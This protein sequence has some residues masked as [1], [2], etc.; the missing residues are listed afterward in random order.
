M[1]LPAAVGLIRVLVLE[2][3]SVRQS[4]KHPNLC[5]ITVDG[6]KADPKQP[7]QNQE[8]YWRLPNTDPRNEGK[9]LFR[10]HTLDLYFW[11]AEDAN[12][13]IGCVSKILQ[14]GQIEILDAPAIQEPQQ[15]VT[16]PVVQKLESV[17]IQDPAYQNGQTRDSRTS[18]IAETPASTASTSQGAARR[19]IHH[20]EEAGAF[21]PMAYN[22]AAPPAP[23]PI[24]HREKTPPPPDS[25]QGTGLAAAAQHDHAQAFSPMPTPLPTQSQGYTSRP[26]YGQSPLSQ[27]FS[28]PPS[29]YT[30]PQAQTAFSPPPPVS[31]RRNSS[32]SSIPQ[33]PQ[34]G[35]TMVNPY[36]ST[37]SAVSIPQSHQ[38]ATSP[39]PQQSL[40]TFGPPPIDP[41]VQPYGAEPKLKRTATAEILG[42]SYVSSEK[43]P[44]QHLQPQ[45]ADYLGSRP[46]SQQPQAQQQP[47]PPGGYANYDYS[48]Q[49]QRHHS[50]S[51]QSN[52][53]DV[54]SQVYRPTEEEAHKHRKH[55]DAG[56]GQQPGRLEQRAAKVDKGVNRLFKRVEKKLG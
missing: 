31:G 24:R 18:S 32:V 4:Y 8:Y 55:S 47:Q 10:L 30:S 27:G 23:E 29:Q 41:D 50:H 40:T 56:Q 19:E 52:D 33:P 9:Y 25:E 38:S 13:F 43:Q 45:Y 28:G 12:S 35:R 21:K 48:Q 7:S 51:S 1:E 14:Q 44:L 15:A 39:Q 53:Y 49:P 17:A 36:G 20:V 26:P 2:S 46:Q 54:H 16:S 37:L 11:K 5:T 6:Y 42:T 34:A 3:V 22:P